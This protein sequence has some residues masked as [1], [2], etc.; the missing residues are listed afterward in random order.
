MDY[1]FFSNL[2]K[3]CLKSL[4]AEN[5]ITKLTRAYVN[6]NGSFYVAVQTVLRY[7]IL[8]IPRRTRDLHGIV[9]QFNCT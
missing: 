8:S 6:E 1:F 4:H 9:Y 5:H 7:I 2:N 3:K